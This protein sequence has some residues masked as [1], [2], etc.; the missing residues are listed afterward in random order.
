MP[1]YNTETLSGRYEPPTRDALSAF[2]L[3]VAQTL[4][5]L[6][7]LPKTTALVIFLENKLEEYLSPSAPAG[8]PNPMTDTDRES[9][10][11]LRSVLG[12]AI[13]TVALGE[14]ACPVSDDRVPWDS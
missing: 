3:S 6:K 9:L 11:R 5:S 4:F 7:D 12:K 13:Q 10:R 1:G 14:G 2:S 8:E